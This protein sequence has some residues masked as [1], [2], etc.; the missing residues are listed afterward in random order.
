M[1]VEAVLLKEYEMFHIFDNCILQLE[2][3]SNT[4]RVIPPGEVRK[5]KLNCP[6]GSCFAHSAFKTPA[7]IVV[8]ESL[9]M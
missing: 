4:V 1:S 5:A 8:A 9:K 2:E 3:V 6:S 7:P